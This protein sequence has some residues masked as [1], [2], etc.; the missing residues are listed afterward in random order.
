MHVYMV[1]DFSETGTADADPVLL[2]E[3]FA[4]YAFLFTIFWALWHRMWLV[5]AGIALGWIFLEGLLYL[6]GTSGN[7]RT[8]FAIG[9]SAFIGFCANDWLGSTLLRRGYSLVGLVAAP[10]FEQALSRWFDF[11]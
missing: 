3:G 6:V 2:R 5:A 8:I 7:V 10:R 1:Y 11:R 4:F 9:F